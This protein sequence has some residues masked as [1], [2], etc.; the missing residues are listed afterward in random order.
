MKGLENQSNILLL[1]EISIKGCCHTYHKECLLDH[2][3]NGIDV[4]DLPIKCPGFGKC[5]TAE[6]SEADLK[7][8]LPLSLQE[9]FNMLS[10]KKAIETA[11]DIGQ[12][13]TADCTYCFVFEKGDREV[14]CLLCKFVHCVEC[15]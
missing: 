6:I 9:R 4:D 7:L 5:Q 1:N 15:K 3:K 12:C 8:I 13:P 11:N 10:F 14:R 2:C